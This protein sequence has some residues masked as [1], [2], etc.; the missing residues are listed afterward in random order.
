[1]YKNKMR[2]LRK[3]KGMTLTDLAAKTG[4]SSGYLCHLERGSRK[5]PSSITMEKIAKELGKN[6][7]EIFYE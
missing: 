6:V 4:L 7:Q 3:Q 2:I 1:M 5:N